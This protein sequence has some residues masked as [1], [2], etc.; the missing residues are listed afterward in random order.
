MTQKARI[1]LADDHELF[2]SGIASMINQQADLEVVGQAGDGLEALELTRD[3]QPDLVVM[4]INMPVC[5][6]VEATRLLRQLSPD[7]II[8]ILTVQKTDEK[9]LECL[10]AGAN[11]YCLKEASSAGLLRALRGML[12][13]ETSLPRELSSRLVSEYSRL[14]RQPDTQPLPVLPTLTYREAEILKLVARGASN[15]EIAARLVIS[16]YTVKGYIR[17]ILEK[18]GVED[19]WAAVEVA[20]QRGLLPPER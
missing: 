10:R 5:N 4:D 11:G 15:K 19:R 20:R 17:T 9:L 16:I 8:M 3:L 7:V 18:L 1:L 13:G 6:G 14:A 2:R 12:A